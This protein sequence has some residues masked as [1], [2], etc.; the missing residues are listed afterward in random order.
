MITA[1]EIQQQLWT[2]GH[3]QHSLEV[4]VTLL[5][6]WYR[7]RGRYTEFCRFSTLSSF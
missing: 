1:P 5:Q 4:F 2:I 3:S 6:L 7:T